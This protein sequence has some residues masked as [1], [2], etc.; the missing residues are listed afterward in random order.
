MKGIL[1]K[2]ELFKQ[3]LAENKV[4]TRR[5]LSPKWVFNEDPDRYKLH[6]YD[7]EE[8][9][10]FFEDLKPEIT[11]WMTPIMG[12]YKEGEKVYLKEP[13]YDYGNGI[14]WYAFDMDEDGRKQ[15]KWSNK[16]FMAERQA[17]YFI[18]I[19]G[20]RIERLQDITR[21]SIRNEG[22]VCPDH[23]GSDNLKYNYK[24]WYIDEWIR[25]WDKINGKKHN[26]DSNPWVWVYEFRLC[27]KRS[28]FFIEDPVE[29]YI[30]QQS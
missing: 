9:G 26:W 30:H 7:E 19:T 20:V 14:I 28:T 23:L 4:E 22:L 21:T 17:R 18:E 10:A 15:T 27:G 8:G 16:L 29:T 2:E 1:F 5:L 13:F 6:N 3:I 25:L 12:R 24:N 11:P